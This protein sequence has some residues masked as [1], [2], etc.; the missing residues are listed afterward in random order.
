MSLCTFRVN[1]KLHTGS[2][3]DRRLVA[4]LATSFP[5]R[6]KTMPLLEKK[7]LESSMPFAF[8]LRFKAL[9]LTSIVLIAAAGAQTASVRTNARPS[10]RITA[11][12]DNAVTQQ[13]PGS[14]PRFAEGAK[15]GAR[16][17][18]GNLLSH[19]RLVLTSSA[20]Q[21]AALQ[22]L[23]GE[24]QDKTS[25]NYHQWLTPESFGTYFGPAQ[26]DIAKVSAWLADQ[27]MTVESVSKGGRVITFSATAGQV[28]TAFHTEIHTIQL[29]NGKT[30]VSN[31]TDIALPTALGGVVAGVA[32]LN[33]IFPTHVGSKGNVSTVQLDANGTPQTP[34]SPTPFYGTAT[35][36]HYVTP[37]D[38]AVIY[39]TT[40]LTSAGIDGT[41]QTIAVLAQSN[42][43]LADV[44]K[45]RSMFG[46]VKN[47]PT[48]TYVD[49]NPSEN[50][51]DVEA[52]LDA[53]WAG[54]LG[55]GAAV[56]FIVSSPNY[57]SGGVDSSA[58]YAVENNIGDVISLSYGGCELNDGSTYTAFYNSLWEQAAAQGQTVF[59]SSG[60]SGAATCESSGAAYA[61][62]IEPNGATYAVNALGSSAYNVAMGG[63]IFVDFNPAQYWGA[64][65]GTTIPFVNALSYIPEA[66]VNQGRLAQNELNSAS[67][68][69]VTGSGIFSDGG[70]ISIFTARP[71]WQTGSGIPTNT[72][73]INVYSGTGIAP[74]YTSDGT[75][76][77][78]PDLVNISANGHDGTLFCASSL[79][80]TSN[81]GGLNNAGIVGGTSVAT[82]VQA[83]IQTLINE[84]NGGRQG[85]ILPILYKLSNAQYTAS[86]TACQATLGTTTTSTPTLPASTCN[87]HDVV[88]GS[89]IVP[90]ASTGTAGIGFSAAVGFDETS[91]LGSMNVY[92]VAT[93]WSTVGLLAT[94]TT[95]K[96]SPA[97]LTHGATQNLSVTVAPAT[98]TGVPT[99]DVSLVAESVA[100]DSPRQYTLTAGTYNGTVAQN[101]SVDG[102]GDSAIAALPAGNYN[103][104]VHYGGDTNYAASNSASVPV[105]I[106]KESSNTATTSYSVST[107]AGSIVTSTFTYG[108][109]AVYLSTSI[110]GSS[111]TGIPTGTV[112]YAIS[113]NGA[114]YGSLTVNVDGS[115]LAYFYAGEAVPN[116]YLKP[117]FAALQPGSYV[118]TS[119]YSGDTTFNSSTTSNTFT[120]SQRATNATFTVPATI[121][122]GANAVF[123][124]SILN[125][126]TAANPQTV[127]PATGTVTFVDTTTPASL[128]TCSLASTLI[129]GS[130]LASGTCSF[131]T[132]AIASSGAHSIQAIYSGDTNYAAATSTA[133][134]T[135]TALTASTLA[136]TGSGTA[137]AGAIYTLRATMNP[138]AATGTVSFF[139]GTTFLGQA[140]LASG[141]ASL[142]L[143]TAATGGSNLAAGTHSFSATYTGDTT[144]NTSTGT[145]SPT[146]AKAATAITLSAPANSTYGQTVLFSV[147]LSRSPTSSSSSYPTTVPL[148]QPT[149]LVNFYSDG[150]LVASGTPAFDPAGYLYY[151]AAGS[152][153]TIPAG[154]HTI[155]ATFVGDNNFSTST[156]GLTP[157]LTVAQLTPVITLSS[158]ATVYNGATS[159]VLTATIPGASTAAAP[160]GLITF[161]D[162]STALGT[163]TAAYSTTAGAFTASYTAT[164]LTGG[165]HRFTAVLTSDTDYAA[166]TSN[167][168]AVLLNTNNV[169]VANGNSTVSALTESG[170]AVTTSAQSGGGTAVAIDNAGDVWS[171]NKTGSKV[172]EYSN[173]GV[174]IS[175]GS[176][177]GGLNA[178]TA[179]AI[180]GAGLVWVA[181]G[182]TAGT[183]SVLSAPGTAVS[184]TGYGVSLSAPTSINI[185]A[186][187]NL[188]VTNSGDN[189]VTEVFGAAT[190][191]TTP[192]SNAV[193]SNSLAARP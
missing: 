53:E 54:A 174:L 10:V 129:N 43:D 91:G 115:G 42:I 119:T 154:T 177:V 74:G 67:S 181:N 35:G 172:S 145:L 101:F 170:T 49:Q 70:G 18:S 143:G 180:D 131:S 152:T 24:Q 77:L 86:T 192:T 39:N 30:H 165:T 125:P 4:H 50:P 60:D 168:L 92:N 57:F 121:T 137:T 147:Y 16:L 153:S 141:V 82:P 75:H 29:P 23:M 151:A 187:G 94:T 173:A 161:Y 138:T 90:T 136:L 44:E 113:R 160:T 190:P 118:V 38:A 175:G 11:K 110:T 8:P 6:E 135:V 176:T 156:A 144:Y 66:P 183:L 72:D 163:A 96:L 41:G 186:S 139:D 123:G 87:F 47:D 9:S 140:G 106:A 7:L 51:D 127:L 32:R 79:C 1:L 184:T 34:G 105:S 193:K 134:V 81:T 19:L 114:S 22:Q 112:T 88:S 182:G 99:G 13:V 64:T 191:V 62:Q 169:W 109:S 28:E 162:G 98:G 14:H 73:G 104:H 84:K 93:N 20:D 128:G 37:G 146:I 108:G 45:F 178:P 111:T 126:S 150:T 120:V 159:V 122:P 85:N 157:T 149:G 97:I 68:A 107:T 52:F 102:Y 33:D 189:S 167:V 15:V 55:P 188:W 76:R 21:E 117:D 31:T 25:A 148:L 12:I 132:T 124:Y 26:V 17:S 185:D 56:N 78:V 116:Y 80:S 59:V 130:N 2:R 100:G 5:L 83:G 65:G 103:V 3:T 133:T 71:S 27:G 46:L 158:P 155:T 69:Y 40:P 171:L 166:A 48:I 63:S 61:G 164:G 58:L 95:F 36:T 89:N 142:A 179:L